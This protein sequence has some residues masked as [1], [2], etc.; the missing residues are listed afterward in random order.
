MEGAQ[1]DGAE[2]Y[3]ET[4]LQLAAA[5]GDASGSRTLRPT[6]ANV[7]FVVSVLRKEGLVTAGLM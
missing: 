6:C 1:Q 2:N 5:A 7:A 3:A 4:P